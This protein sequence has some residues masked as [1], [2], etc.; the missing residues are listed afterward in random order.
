MSALRVTA[1]PANAGVVST[2]TSRNATIFMAYAFTWL[3]VANMLS[4][5]EMTFEF[6]S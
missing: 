4:A 1:V 3:A 5:V 6:I 2:V